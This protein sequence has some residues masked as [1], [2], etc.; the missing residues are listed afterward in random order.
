M[1]LILYNP[2]SRNGANTNI[3]EKVVKKMKK[4]HESVRVKSLLEIEDKKEFLSNLDPETKI[5]IV[6]GDGTLNRVANEIRGIENLPEIYL[7][8]A[9]TG[10]DFLRSLKNKKKLT[11]IDQYLINLPNVTFKNEDIVFLNGIGLG[12]DALVCHT[13]EESKKKKNKLNFFSSV[14]KSL[15]NFQPFDFEVEIDGKRQRFE[16]AWFVS[17]MNSKYFGGGMKIAPKAD[18]ESDTLEVVVIHGISKFKLSLFF[19]LIYLGWHTGIKNVKVFTGKNIKV[20]S[21]LPAY[22]QI[23]G[24]V[25][26]NVL[27][28]EARR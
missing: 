12:F 15:K 23:D 8:K 14:F 26:D 10:N 3:V 28:L 7:Y 9:G 18:R 24:D 13:V 2:I 21:D 22:V 16:D 20:F 19:P 11:R 25:Y 1:Y 5:I 4:K 27:E 6:G 17:I